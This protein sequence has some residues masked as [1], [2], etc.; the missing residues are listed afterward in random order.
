M[1]KEIKKQ[2]IDKKE[3]TN[4]ISAITAMSASIL[5]WGFIILLLPKIVKTESAVM[6]LI[7]TV[8]YVLFFASCIAHCVTSYGFFK[9]TDNFTGIF[10]G[11]ISLVSTLFCIFNLRFILVMLFSAFGKDETAMTEFLGTQASNWTCFVFALII[12]IIIGILGI[13]RLVSAD[14]K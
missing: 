11:L 8:G 5:M 6:T 12:M 7:F 13:I 14:R 1:P 10:H 4:R 3:K 2:I 9:A